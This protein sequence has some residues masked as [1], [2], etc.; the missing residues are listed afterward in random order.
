MKLMEMMSTGHT[1]IQNLVKKLSPPLGMRFFIFH[2]GTTYYA[3]AW[4]DDIFH[5]VSEE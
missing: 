1:F 3:F 2:Y 4:E 5:N